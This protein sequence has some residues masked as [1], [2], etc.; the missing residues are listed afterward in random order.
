VLELIAQ[1]AQSFAGLPGELAS[2]C[3]ALWRAGLRVV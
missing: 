2:A 1:I 3:R